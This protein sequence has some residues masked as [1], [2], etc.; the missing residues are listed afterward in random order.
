MVRDRPVTESH[1]T[2]DRLGQFR[3]LLDLLAFESCI[4]IPLHVAGHIEHALFLFH[5]DATMFSAAH[6]RSARATAALV[7]ALL[8]GQA[9]D[10][11]LRAMSG[12]F[13]SGQLAASFSHEVHNRLTSLDLQIQ[14]LNEDV[15]RVAR[16]HTSFRGSASFQA[17]QQA[18][19]EALQASTDF[20]YT[21]NDFKG[22]MQNREGSTIELNQVIRQAESLMQTAARR[23]RTE[24]RLDLKE[25]LP[26]AFG[27]VLGLQQAFLNLMLNGI[28]HMEIKRYGQRTLTISTASRDDDGVAWV[29]ARVSDTGPG[30]HRQQWDRVF[31]LGFTTRPEGS[32]LG[33]F[34]ARSLMTSLGGRISI[35]SS[36]I[37]I[38]TTFLVELP[39][40]HKKRHG[41]KENVR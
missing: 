16:E 9:L 37:P 20:K 4:G 8:E 40:P 2:R 34:I 36:A 24:I 41:G 27:N 39:V 13:L 28:Q 19:W 32:G 33:L 10:D 31:D 7:S 38:G 18:L 3:N 6:L 5:K 14:N 25:D 21:V 29:Q 12:L 26:P 11:R 35:E 22:L 30:I 15:A 23:A 1:V 17:V